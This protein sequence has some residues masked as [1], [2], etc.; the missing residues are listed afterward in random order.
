[1]PDDVRRLLS[2]ERELWYRRCRSEF[3]PFCIEALQS[4]GHSPARHHRLLIAELEALLKGDFD[5]LLV[6]LPYGSGKST[7]TDRLF[8]PWAMAHKPGLQ[9][10]FVSNTETF[11]L[12]MSG[13][14]QRT[15]KENSAALGYDLA[16]DRKDIWSTTNGSRVLAVSVGGTVLGFRGNLIVAD[17]LIRSREEAYSQGQ[18]DKLY[19]WFTNDLLSRR[20][21]DLKVVVIGTPQHEDDLLARLQ[22]EPGGRWRVLR[23]PALAEANDPLGRLPGEPLWVDDPRSPSYANDTLRRRDE[24]LATLPH[25]W[26]GPYQLAPYPPEGDLFHPEKMP[27]LDEPPPCFKRVR[28]WDLAASA[29]KG[30]ATVG[31]LI[32]HRMEHGRVGDYAILD[33]VHER[34]GPQDVR[35]LVMRTAIMDGHTTQIWLPQDPGSAG[36]DLAD[37]LT[38]MLSGY[39]A[40]AERMSGSKATRAMIPAAQLNA[41]RI[42]LVKAPWNAPLKMELAAFPGGRHDDI[43]DALSLAFSKIETDSALAKWLRL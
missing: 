2:L 43:V 13:H 42:A 27:V 36:L 20:L 17:D 33:L 29:G 21:P 40:K 16:T 24:L 12:D 6:L 31:I 14:I 38:R 10:I 26:Y 30:D 37:S 32:G 3:L 35:D 9:V 41:G 4:Y 7:Y 19:G 5:R 18:R 28:G 11:T 23:L 39:P 34:L 25:L 8:I 22:D 1:M 15:V